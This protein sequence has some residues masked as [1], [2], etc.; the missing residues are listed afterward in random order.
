VWVVAVY[1]SF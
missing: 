1:H